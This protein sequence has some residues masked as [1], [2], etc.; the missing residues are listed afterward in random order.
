MC[1]TFP[2]YL[3]Q[4]MKFFDLKFTAYNSIKCHFEDGTNEREKNVNNAYTI[5][6]LMIEY[7]RFIASL[8]HMY[9]NKQIDFDNNKNANAAAVA[10]QEQIFYLIKF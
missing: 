6:S 5:L 9:N 7:E 1:R 10:A 8:S 2:K 4:E 3:R